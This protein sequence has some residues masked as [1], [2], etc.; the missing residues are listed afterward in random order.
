MECT[1]CGKSLVS[2]TG[3]NLIGIKLSAY[4]DVVDLNEDLERQLG[5]YDNKDYNFCWECLLDALFGISTSR[6]RIP[7]A[8]ED[9]ML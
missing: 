3:V 8:I 9:A 5:K 2:K 1:N 6:L 4:C 7:K